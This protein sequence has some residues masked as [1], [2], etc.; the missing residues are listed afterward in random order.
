MVEPKAGAI[1]HNGDMLA[2]ERRLAESLFQRTDGA[3]VIV[4]TPTLAQGM[5]LPAQ[6]A[7]LAGN[8]RN[9]DKKRQDLK[10]HELLNAAGRAGRA[11]HLANGVVLLV[12]EPVVGFTAAKI[13]DGAFKALKSVLPA[14]DQCVQIDDPMTSLLDEIQS[15]KPPSIELRYFLSRLKAGE[16]DDTAVD[17]AVEMVRNSLAGFR[18][19]LRGEDFDLKLGALRTALVAEADEVSLDVARVAAFTGLSAAGLQAVSV[20]LDAQIAA[21]PSTVT[22]WCD[23]LVDLVAADP[24]TFM[25]LF[26][27]DGDI[28]KAV[29]RGSKS[30]PALSP[31]EFARLK[32]GLKSWVTGQ[33][34]DQIEVALGVAPGAVDACPRARDLVLKLANRRLYL[35]AAAIA[36]LAKEKLAAVNLAAVNPAVLEILPIAVRRGWDTPEKAAFAHRHPAIRGRVAAHRAFEARLGAMVPT[37]GRTFSEV[38]THLDAHL[39]F[40]VLKP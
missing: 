13:S 14:N 33:A 35:I 25:A 17:A 26:A 28:V 22:A 9:V 31:A 16:P 23:W 8:V 32:A 34:F 5:N 15:D 24:T 36:E 1:P 11:G 7:I 39:A 6:V 29:C 2:P 4:A 10:Q 27:Q 3:K 19:R 37:V 30:D 21:L 12:P 40:G 20:V 18:A 38:L